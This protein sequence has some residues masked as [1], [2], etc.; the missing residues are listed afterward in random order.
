MTRTRVSEVRGG[1]CDA[2]K[3]NSNVGVGWTAKELRLTFHCDISRD[4]AQKAC[5]KMEAVIKSFSIFNS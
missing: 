2:V 4:L 3:F 1:Y 5:D